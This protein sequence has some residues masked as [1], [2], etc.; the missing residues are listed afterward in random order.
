[1]LD[2]NNANAVYAINNIHGYANQMRSAAAEGLNKKYITNL[3]NYITIPQLIGVVYEQSLGVDDNNYPLLN[4]E[5]NYQIYDIVTNWIY[6]ADLSKLASD[7]LIECS[8][9]D[10]SNT[11]MFWNK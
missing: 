9:D 2:N 7:N 1:M 11:M 5:A 4:E 8:W 3:D 6:N 10:K